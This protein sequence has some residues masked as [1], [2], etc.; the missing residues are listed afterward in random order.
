MN[1][2][3]MGVVEVVIILAVLICLS[4]IFRN[5]IVE[6]VIWLLKGLAV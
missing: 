6:F 5:Q 4:L 3:G 1:N 2:K